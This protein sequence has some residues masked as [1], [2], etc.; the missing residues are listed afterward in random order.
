MHRHGA[1]FLPG[2][3]PEPFCTG[4]SSCVLLMHRHG[5]AA[6]GFLVCLS[7]ILIMQ[8][9]RCDSFTPRGGGQRERVTITNVIV[10]ICESLPISPT[11]LNPL[12]GTAAAGK[13]PLTARG[14]R[15]IVRCD[16]GSLDSYTLQTFL[17]GI[18]SLVF[19]YW[20]G[21]FR[22]FGKRANNIFNYR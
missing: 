9:C 22:F 1:E 3:V 19:H 15:G 16:S 6:S 14:Y 13:L 4:R 21:A 7:R 18:G 20:S 11:P 12:W 10:R 2:L 5:A 17:L 8:L